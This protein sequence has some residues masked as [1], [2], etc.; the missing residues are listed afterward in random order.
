MTRGTRT[1]RAPRWLTDYVSGEE[2]IYEENG[3]HFALFIDRDPITFDEAVKSSKWRKVVDIEI[4]AVQRNN[5]WELTDLLVG[6]KTIGV[7]WIFNTKVK[8]NGEIENK[9]G[10][11]QKVYHLKKALYGLKQALRAWYSRIE[12]YFLKI[13]FVKCPYEH[14]LFIKHQEGGNDTAM[15]IEFKTSMMNEFEMT[16]LGK[17]HYFL[18]IEVKQSTNKIF[19]G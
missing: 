5:I 17:M 2:L 10:Q 9:K 8:E 11:E 19:V 16:D 15:F 13:G 1:R 12:S 4:D 18:C 14:T 7:K 3:V 6:G